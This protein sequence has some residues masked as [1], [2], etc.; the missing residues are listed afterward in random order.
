MNPQER[1][2]LQKMI[3]ANDV[4]DQTELIRN[5]KHSH[6]LQ[7]DINELIRLKLLGVVDDSELIKSCSF[8]FTQY[9]D[10]YNKIIR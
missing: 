2:M 7:E 3:S 1:L 9:T 4:E 10:L 5:L 8:L 6:Q